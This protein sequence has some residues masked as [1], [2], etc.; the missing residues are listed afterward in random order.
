MDQPFI[1]KVKNK[2]RLRLAKTCA[3]GVIIFV[4]SLRGFPQYVPQRLVL[5][6]ALDQH[7]L[8]PGPKYVPFIICTVR[9]E[10]DIVERSAIQCHVSS[11]NDRII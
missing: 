9:G 5:L 6:E 7:V 10:K 11:I 3:D 4:S 8:V 1:G 2:R